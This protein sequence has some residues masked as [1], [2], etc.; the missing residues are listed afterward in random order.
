MRNLAGG[1][2]L[3]LFFPPSLPFVVRRGIVE[4]REANYEEQHWQEAGGDDERVTMMFAGPSSKAQQDDRAKHRTWA[5]GVGVGVKGSITA[6]QRSM[7]VFGMQ[8]LANGSYLTTLT[9]PPSPP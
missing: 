3:V 6:V 5:A 2:C 1:R 8:L 4:V 9:C 7:A